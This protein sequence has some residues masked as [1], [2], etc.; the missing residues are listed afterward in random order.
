MIGFLCAV[1]A[2]FVVWA[3]I[4]LISSHRILRS[5]HQSVGRTFAKME[6]RSDFRREDES[7]YRQE[8]VSIVSDDG[9]KLTGWLLPCN[10]FTEKTDMERKDP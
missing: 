4:V 7:S 6:K 3:A 10:Y 2:L 1:G 9:L 5:R 8:K